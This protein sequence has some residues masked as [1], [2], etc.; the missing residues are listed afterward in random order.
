[1]DTLLKVREFEEENGGCV[2]STHPWRENRVG[3]VDP[4]PTGLGAV[5]VKIVVGEAG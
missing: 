1:M 2:A 3:L 5:P 4:C